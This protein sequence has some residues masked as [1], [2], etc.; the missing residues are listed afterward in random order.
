MS[1]GIPHLLH[2]LLALAAAA[3]LTPGAGA[4]LEEVVSLEGA[5]IGAAVIDLASGE[6]LAIRDGAGFPVGSGEVFL[7]AR[8]V[9]ADEAEGG[10]A[11]WLDARGMIDTQVDPES[12]LPVSTSVSDA[13][14]A[15]RLLFSGEEGRRAIPGPLD[16]GEGQAAS[17]GYGWEL[18]G[19][20]DTGAEHRSFVLAAVSPEGRE[21]GLLLLTDDLCCPGKSDLALLLLWTAAMNTPQDLH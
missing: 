13:A 20:V 5:R 16:L 9:C 6:T 14:C 4:D 11:G 10:L 19:W 2:A 21:L 1:P 3:A 12:G 18:S 8:S 15:L 7:L 17:V